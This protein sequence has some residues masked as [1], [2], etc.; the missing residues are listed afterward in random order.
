MCV[1]N[2]YVV[3]T[4]RDMCEYVSV[5]VC[6][7][8]TYGSLRCVRC[9]K[10]KTMF[11]CVGISA[12]EVVDGEISKVDSGWFCKNAI[13]MRCKQER[14]TTKVLHSVPGTFDTGKTPPTV[15]GGGFDRW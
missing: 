4:W 2:K 14:T 3:I 5:Q 10:V 1:C 13:G 12:V 11:H 9:G 6:W 8:C 15:G 7:T